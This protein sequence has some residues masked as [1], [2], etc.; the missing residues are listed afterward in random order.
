MVVGVDGRLHYSNDK[1]RELGVALSTGIV[2]APLRDLAS[3]AVARGET[4]EAVT[5]VRRR[6]ALADNQLL[7]IATVVDDENLAVISVFDAGSH[8]AARNAHREFVVNVSHE[9]KTPIG[10]LTLMAEALSGAADS[11][12]VVRDFAAKIEREAQ[13]MGM[14]VDQFIELSRVQSSETV[15]DGK[16]HDLVTCVADAVEGVRALAE[17]RKVT[18]DVTAFP[19]TIISCERRTMAMAIR[20]LLENAVRYSPENS[21]VT[22][23]ARRVKDAVELSVKDQGI[24][25][26]PVDLPRIFDR[27]YRADEARDRETGGTGIGLAIVKHVARQHGG[28]VQV[29]SE[30]SV[31]STFTLVLPFVPPSRP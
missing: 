13:R 7:A 5:T 16:P 6:H 9:L 27:F 29:W 8:A 3:R 10:A 21:R 24:G 18:I 17:S 1:G 28:R 12:D 22:V 26:D 20:N 25:I 14:L 2:T 30:P 19:R 4:T 23:S 15:I 11:P 31:G